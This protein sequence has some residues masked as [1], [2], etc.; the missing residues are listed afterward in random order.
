MKKTQDQLIQ[1][2]KVEGLKIDSN[3]LA[4]VEFWKIGSRKIIGYA[5]MNRKHM[6]LLSCKHWYHAQRKLV[7]LHGLKRCRK[8][9]SE[10][11][12]RA[13]RRLIESHNLSVFWNHAA[14][15]E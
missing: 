14:R 9:I 10:N 6:Y 5:F 3:G 2:L 1:Q 12:K 13:M 4:S 7:F 8:C 15:G 11:E